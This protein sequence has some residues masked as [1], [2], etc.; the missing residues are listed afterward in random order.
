MSHFGKGNRRAS[1]LKAVQIEMLRREY[2]LG[3]TQRE[4][5]AKYGLCTAQVGRIVRGESWKDTGIAAGYVRMQAWDELA[6]GGGEKGPA[7]GMAGMGEAARISALRAQDRIQ[8][9]MAFGGPGP[10]MAVPSEIISAD[11]RA[12]AEGFI[13]KPHGVVGNAL[14]GS[15]LGEEP[16]E[17][18]KAGPVVEWGDVE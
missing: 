12:K 8:A 1:K 7:G 18:A 9:D 5:G 15:A 3:A 10:G 17:G 2:E 6:A 11:V 16:E 14:T 13:G 4:L